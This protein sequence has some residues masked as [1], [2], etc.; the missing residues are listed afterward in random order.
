MKLQIPDVGDKLILIKD[1]TFSLH[2]EYRNDSLIEILTGK[3]YNWDRDKKPFPV[4]LLK[5]TI[6]IVDRVYIRKNT[7][8]FSSLSFRIDSCS[9]SK[10]NKKRFWAKLT[11]VNTMQ[12]E[13]VD[14]NKVLHLPPLEYDMLVRLKKG[15]IYRSERIFVAKPKNHQ[16]HWQYPKISNPVTNEFFISCRQNYDHTNIFKVVTSSDLKDEEFNYGSQKTIEKRIIKTTYQL[17]SLDG[18]Y[19]HFITDSDSALRSKIKDLYPSAFL[20]INDKS[21]LSK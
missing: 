5:H 13:D 21:S 19:V 9:N 6:L 4:T 15:E 1:W 8:D 11:D 16:A 3:K 2:Y 18:R 17:L 7:N 12:I 14:F 20:K 10:L